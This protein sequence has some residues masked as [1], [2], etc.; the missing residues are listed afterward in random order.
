MSQKLSFD[1]KIPEGQSVQIEQEETFENF[2]GQFQQFCSKLICIID[3]TTLRYYDKT[4][5]LPKNIRFDYKQRRGKIVEYY[6]RD[7]Q[8]ESLYCVFG[9][10]AAKIFYPRIDEIDHSDTVTIDPNFVN[11]VMKEEIP[12]VIKE[13]IAKISP[14]QTSSVPSDM[15]KARRPTIIRPIRDKNIRSSGNSKVIH[16]EKITIVDNGTKLTFSNPNYPI[17]VQTYES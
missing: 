12:K 9:R 15:Y 5:G 1:I 13:E 11:V 8:T 16:H 3:G 4:E 7:I 17:E 14:E 6:F 10:E 2:I